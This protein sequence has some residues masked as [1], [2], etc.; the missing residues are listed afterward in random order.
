MKSCDMFVAATLC[1]L[2]DIFTV[3]GH[4]LIRRTTSEADIMLLQ[5][6]FPFLNALSSK[7]SAPFERMGFFVNGA[8]FADI[9]LTV[10]RIRKA[11]CLC[12]LS[13]VS[14]DEAFQWSTSSY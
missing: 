12:N 10:R 1:T 11:G 7:G 4:M 8:L 13:F 6:H 5:K 2:Y 14:R 9:R 3:F